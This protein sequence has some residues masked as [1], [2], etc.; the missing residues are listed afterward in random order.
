M[1]FITPCICCHTTLWNINARKQAISDKLQGSV[2][3]YIKYGGD[4]NNQIKKGLFL[5]LSVKKN[6][7]KSA[8]IWQSYKQEGGWLVH[9]FHVVTLPNIYRF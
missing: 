6:V 1:G 2:A 3:T 5:S 9:I 8:N 7:F 4:F